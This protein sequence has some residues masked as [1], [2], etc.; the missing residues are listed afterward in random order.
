[1]SALLW[2]GVAVLGGAGAI[3]RFALDSFVSSRFGGDFPLG[4][5]A[6]NLSGAFLLGFLVGVSL[7]GHAYLLAGTAVLGSYTTFSTWMLETH[8][9]AED[10]EVQLAWL[11]V[12][13]SL[14]AGLGAAALGKALGGAL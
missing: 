8:R 5:L 4:T 1:V 9:P 10:G 12:G 11:N 7:E 13:V 14:V 6:V 2:V 3:G